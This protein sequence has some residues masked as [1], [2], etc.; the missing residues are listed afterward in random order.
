MKLTL[1][2]TCTSIIFQTAQ[3]SLVLSMKSSS[4]QLSPPA[5]TESRRALIEKAKSIDP[6]LVNK[7]EKKSASSFT[8][9]SYSSVGWSNRLGTVL[10][11]ISIPGVYSADRP[12][13]WNDI[14][15]GGRMTVVELQS[16][17]N[18]KPDLFVHSPVFL[19]PPLIAALEKIGTVKHVVSPNYEHVKYARQ[20]GEYYK[21]A[22]IW[23][24][25]G[26]MEKE[27]L[28]RWTGEIPAGCRPPGYEFN[29]ESTKGKDNMWDWNELQP[30]HIDCERL[31]ILRTP[32][33]SEV[34]FYHVPSKSLL[35]TD[36]YWNYPRLDGITNANYADKAALCGDNEEKD[37]GVWEL[38][39]DV[40]RIPFS[41]RLV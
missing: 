21:D 13:I 38:A 20:W 2:I 10:T 15:V 31:P 40:G 11:P 36:S 27:P 14:D 18:E 7:D 26:I 29:E 34:V 23:G 8:S 24:C 16:S 33:F 39:P 6:A 30:I 1:F 12:F 19:D 25:P 37:F 17:T 41:S 9:G 3:S 35:V 4:S 22:N 32:F 28:V 5:Y